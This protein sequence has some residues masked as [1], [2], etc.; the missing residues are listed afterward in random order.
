MKRRALKKRYGRAASGNG[1]FA[2]V[3]VRRGANGDVYP[4]KTIQR[5]ETIEEAR[6]AKKNTIGKPVI[7]E[8]DSHFGWVVT[9]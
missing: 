4:I 9:S 8:H 7:M 2:L 1:R 6:A 3:R 5:F